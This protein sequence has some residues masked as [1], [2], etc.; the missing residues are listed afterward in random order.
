MRLGKNGLRPF[1][2]CGSEGAVAPSPLYYSAD[3]ACSTTH[4]GQVLPCLVQSKHPRSVSVGTWSPML[5]IVMTLSHFSHIT[6]TLRTR[7]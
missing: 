2:I 4:R 3:S 5:T 6:A 1:R 7:R